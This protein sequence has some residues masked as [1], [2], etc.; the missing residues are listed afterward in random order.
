MKADTVLRRRLAQHASQGRWGL[1][2]G[3]GAVLG[4]IG[5][6]LFVLALT[7]G[8]AERAW[9]LF[10][11]NWVY[12]TGLTAGSLALVA[13]YKV[14]NAKW[15][16]LLVR[17]ASATVAFLPVILVGFVLVFTL[18]YE[19]V[20]GHMQ[21]EL[22]SL[23]HGKAVWLSKPWMVTRLGLGLAALALV[24]WALVRRDLAPDAWE[25]A[26]EAEGPRRRALEGLARGFD[27]TAA[28][29]AAVE[30]RV[31]RLAPVYVVL[32]AVVLTLVAFD[33]MMALQPHW[34]SNLL[35]GWF[36]MGSF[37]GGN[38]LLALLALAGGRET[39]TAHLI[40]PK[41][42]HDLGKMIFGFSVFW[43]YLMWSQFLVIWYGNL[44]EETGFV[45]ARIWGPWRPVARLVF[46][47]MFLIPFVG[48]LGVTP[49]KWPVTLGLFSGVILAALWLERYLMVMPSITA[50]AGPVFGLP[51]LAPT[52][53]FVGLFLLA[54]G[55]A[56][57]RFPM[58][59]PRLGELTLQR[60][61]HHVEEPSEFLHEEAERDY[62][63]EAAIEEE[64]R[65]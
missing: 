31:A 55:L 28:G 36:F 58:I 20:Y 25:A 64:K 4:M 9:Q 7:G 24:G 1:F 59:S 62:V 3:L 21:E 60:E 43:T 39:G 26:R 44:P 18:G 51:E 56:A 5:A 42:R 22:H 38:A 27:G 34:F 57:R 8:Q 45:F 33:G 40:S 23:P 16:G 15:S 65:H 63:S 32:Y 49:K 47:G 12:F 52:L 30:G 37:L 54:Y 13:V 14:A 50:E 19:H 11:V 17:F 48:L 46:C 61:S 2:V 10:H 6:G 35:G 41:Q 53:L 29:L